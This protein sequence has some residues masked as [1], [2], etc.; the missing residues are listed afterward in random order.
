MLTMKLAYYREK[1]K[2][3]QRELSSLS[4][5]SIRQIRDIENGRVD[6]RRIRADTVIRLARCFGVSAEDLM[7]IVGE[8]D[9][10]NIIYESD[11]IKFS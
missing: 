10:G 6:P 2:L 5:V 1:W 4:G 8:Y 9:D 3:T 11:F 7:D